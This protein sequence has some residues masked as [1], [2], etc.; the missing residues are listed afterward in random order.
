MEVLDGVSD[1]KIYIE[2][3]SLWYIFNNNSNLFIIFYYGVFVI[4][5]N[6]FWFF[7]IVFYGILFI[8]F[9]DEEIELRDIKRFNYIDKKR[10][11]LGFKFW[12]RLFD[13]KYMVFFVIFILIMWSR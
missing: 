8:N 11:K 9:L 2:F 5:V 12:L 6:F 10:V 1:Y 3:Y 4:G 7:I 13:L